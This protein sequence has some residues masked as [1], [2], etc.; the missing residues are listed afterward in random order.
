[1][2]LIIIT[3]M[4]RKSWKL[5][6]YSLP[7]PPCSAYLQSSAH[8]SPLWIFLWPPS[9]RPIEPQPFSTS[10]A[11]SLSLSLG[12]KLASSV[13]SKYELWEQRHY[14][15][16]RVLCSS[17]NPARTQKRWPHETETHHSCHSVNNKSSNGTSEKGP[18]EIL[19]PNF[20]VNTFHAS[21]G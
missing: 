3:T 2:D 15:V 5:S 19:W 20:K 18:W 17:W 21:I 12:T 1:M 13:L 9:T 7:P 6:W 14:C 10:L 4:Y 16:S 11:S 8:V